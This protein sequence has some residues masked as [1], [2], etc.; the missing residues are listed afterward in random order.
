[1]LLKEKVALIVG[2]KDELGSV[3]AEIMAQEGAKIVVAE[4][5]ADSGQTLVRK[6]VAVGAEGIY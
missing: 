1:M 2:T 6:I 3:T 5:N 4:Q